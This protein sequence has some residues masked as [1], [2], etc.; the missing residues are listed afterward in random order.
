[1]SV[2]TS[3]AIAIGGLAAAGGAITAGALQSSATKSAANTEQQTAN[4]AL[5]FQ[6]QQYADQQANEKPF[7]DEGKTALSQL[8]GLTGPD[9][10]LLAPYGK[11]FDFGAFNAP[12]GVDESND[13]G[14]AF[15][16]AEGQKALQ[17]SEAA[18]GISG[19]AAIK[20]ADRY[21]QDYA[22]NEYSN[23]YNRALQN[24][25][26]NYG[27]ALGQF[28]T[29]YGVFQNDQS[30]QF[31]RLAALAGIG[32][33]ANSQLNAAGTATAGNVAG[34]ETGLGTNLANLTT[35]SANATAGGVVGAT[36]A[37]NNTI[38]NYQN[39]QLLQ[40]ILGQQQNQSGYGQV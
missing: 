28:N 5:D 25:A 23:V 36:N 20:A 7:L 35:S 13:P 27:T 17:R 3:T 31:N 33:T 6:K 32:Q 37:I 34:I 19:G 22:S 18:N 9:G 4:N 26:T 8:A 10:K 38:G 30:N 11:T 29:N 2:A 14:Y 40:K 12:T 1:M 15:R 39:Y 21:S 24:Y 16:L